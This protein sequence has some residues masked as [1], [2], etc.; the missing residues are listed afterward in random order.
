MEGP[1]RYRASSSARA[2][3]SRRHAGG[4]D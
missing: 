2:S 3:A 1:A 4:R